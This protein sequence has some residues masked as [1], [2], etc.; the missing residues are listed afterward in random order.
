MTNGA[1]PGVAGAVRDAASEPSETG[2]DAKL[3][4]R[5]PTPG[6]RPPGELEAL[7]KVWETPKGWQ[8]FSAV[9]KDI[10]SAFSP[11]DMKLVADKVLEKCDALDGLADGM[12]HNL[13]ACQAA[14]DI[15]ALQ[16]TGTGTA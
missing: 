15:R 4:A 14:F 3:Y 6:G 13:P 1:T 12:V 16:C 10:K 5:F 2:F 9:N 11:S 8:A 7:E